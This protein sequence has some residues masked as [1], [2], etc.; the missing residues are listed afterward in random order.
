MLGR[1]RRS[2]TSRASGRRMTTTSN[3]PSISV[4]GVVLSLSFLYDH[5]VLGVHHILRAFI[6]HFIAVNAQCTLV[7]KQRKYGTKLDPP[8]NPTSFQ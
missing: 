8:K 6:F 2:F 5:V 7:P 1:M 3:K 4:P